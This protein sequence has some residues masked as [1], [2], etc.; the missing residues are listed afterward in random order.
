MAEKAKTHGLHTLMRRVNARGI[1]AIDGRTAAAKAVL[2]WRGELLRD[3]GGDVSAQKATLVDLAVRT[4]LYVDHID[5]FLMAQPSLVNKRRK[6]IIPVL[7]ERQ[8]LV[9]SLSRLLSLLGLDRQPR[10][11]PALKDY[12]EAK[13]STP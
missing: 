11:L 10:P 5:V 3:L 1:S 2:Q 7:R 12:I 9:D 13:G 4:K 6:S 8:Q